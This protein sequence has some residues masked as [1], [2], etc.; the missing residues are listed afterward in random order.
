MIDELLEAHVELLERSDREQGVRGCV[1]ERHRLGRMD[2]GPRLG[3]VGSSERDQEGDR[4]N[5]HGR[6]NHRFTFNGS[7]Y[8]AGAEP[9]LFLS[10]DGTASSGA[11]A[12]K[13]A[14][15]GK[16][17][18]N[19]NPFASQLRQ[20][21]H[22]TRGA[23]NLVTARGTG[24]R[25][26]PCGQNAGAIQIEPYGIGGASPLPPN[27]REDARSAPLPRRHPSRRPAAETRHPNW[28]ETA[29][30]PERQR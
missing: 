5:A 20:L 1:D 19:A 8:L 24:K 16:F 7:G 30:R 12:P 2:K 27:P 22:V 9:E 21:W 10:P 3:R 26:N 6:R 15:A 29:A 4:P 11:Q 18:A 25:A 17:Y 14:T 28:R 13:S 23:R